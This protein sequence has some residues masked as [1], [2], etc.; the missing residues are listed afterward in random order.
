MGKKKE[1][2]RGRMEERGRGCLSLRNESNLEITSGIPAALNETQYRF[3]LKGKEKDDSTR[4]AG[5]GGG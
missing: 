3:C 2:G 1:A 4:S 5:G